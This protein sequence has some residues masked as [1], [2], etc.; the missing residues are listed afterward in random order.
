MRPLGAYQIAS[1]M[2]E[3]GYTVKVIDFC[4]HMTTTD[5]VNITKHYI[6]PNTIAIGVSSTF[7]EDSRVN[8]H[9]SK[10]TNYTEPEWVVNARTIIEQEYPQL[11]WVLGGSSSLVNRLTLDWVKF[12]GHAEDE[13]LSYMDKK[14][15]NTSIRRP[16]DILNCNKRYH[17]TDFISNKEVLAL[18]LGRGCQ[19]K[20]KFCRYPNIGK[21]PKTYRRSMECVKAEMLFNFQTFGTTKYLFVDETVNE[22]YDK[23]VALAALAKELPFK[24]EWVGYIRADLIYVNPDMIRLLHA[25]GMISCYMGIESLNPETSSLIG[26]GWMGRHGKEF[27]VHLKN[28]WEGKLGIRFFMSFIVGLPHETKESLLSTL[29]W[30]KDNNFKSWDF[31]SLNI[32]RDNTNF[33][34]SEF[35][36]NYGLYGY[37]FPNPLNDSY[38]E[39]DIWNTNSAVEFAKFLNTDNRNGYMPTSFDLADISN[40]GYTIEDAVLADRSEKSLSEFRNQYLKEYIQKSLLWPHS[41]A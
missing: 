4:S 12:H 18:E 30:L 24:L 16:Y 5:L 10:R 31:Y 9:L 29:A 38:W 20:C 35:D 8:E 40:M 34:K 27:L 21:K 39:N 13:F 36:L 26:K 1:W 32:H 28:E 15:S 19:F 2:R 11:D 3:A 6:T 33:W 37:R 23:V 22:D 41:K 17:V 7:W 25:S 14:T